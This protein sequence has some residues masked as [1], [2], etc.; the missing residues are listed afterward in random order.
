MTN[1]IASLSR[2]LGASWGRIT[3]SAIRGCRT[4]TTQATP[5]GRRRSRE[6]S[7]RWRLARFS[8]V[9]RSA[10]LLNRCLCL[11]G[12]FARR[13]VREWGRTMTTSRARHL[14]PAF[15]ALT[16]LLAAPAGAGWEPLGGPTR[17]GVD[18]R[19]A[20]SAPATLYASV[21]DAEVSRLSFLW[22]SDDAGHT[23]RSLQPR[24]MRPLSALVVD[25]GQADVAWAWVPGVS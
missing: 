7:R 24:L 1:G 8:S 25:P 10:P 14:C 21:I 6:N 19:I 23:W 5:H 16:A 2:A 11:F 12:R 18:L 17:L 15:F 3:R 22:R 9:I 13:Y 4:K 20:P